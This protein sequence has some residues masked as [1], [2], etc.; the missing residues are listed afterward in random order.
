MVAVR[1]VERGSHLAGSS[2]R[3]QR[4]E[5][6]W[7]DVYRCVA[8]NKHPLRSERNWSPYK[9]WT[10][11]VICNEI[12]DHIPDLELFCLDE[13]DPIADEQMNTI[14]VPETLETK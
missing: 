12:D 8:W 13:E 3:N 4:I 10:N 1:G 11:S 6:L 2:T 5:R 14:V 7:R 9:I